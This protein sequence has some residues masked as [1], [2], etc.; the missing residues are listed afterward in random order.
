[1]NTLIR[2]LV[3]QKMSR[4]T[5][6]ELEKLGGK[7]GLKISLQDAATVIRIIRSKNVDLFDEK[8]RKSLLKEIARQTNPEL[9]RNME[10]LFQ[11]FLNWAR[12]QGF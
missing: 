12:R 8:A 4:M 1:M 5:A 9:T 3:N 2:Q 6:G 11:R 10:A 7:Y